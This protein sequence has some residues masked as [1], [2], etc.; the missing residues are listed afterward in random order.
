MSE[1]LKFLCEKIPQFRKSRLPALY[2]DFEH[3]RTINPEG[4]HANISAWLQGLAA[5]A[6]AAAIPT[7]NKRPNLLSFSLN[8][9]LL[10]ALENENV[11]PLSLG[12][13]V[14]EGI[15]NGQLIPREEYMKAF[16][17]IYEKSWARW[18]WKALSQGL[19][20]LGFYRNPKLDKSSTGEFVVLENIEAAAMKAKK[21]FSNFQERHDR[22]FTR[23]KFTEVFENVFDTV[24]PLSDSDMELFL[25]YLARDAGLISYN[26]ELVKLRL[27]NETDQITSDD[28]TI[29]SLKKLI[30][31]LNHQIQGL[32]LR[33]GELTHSAKEA[34]LKNNRTAAL[35]VLKSKSLINQTLEKRYAT[36]AQ[37][38]DVYLKIIQAS[39]QVELVKVMETSTKVL[40]TLNEEVNALGPAEKVVD[41]LQDQ[42]QLVDEINT[43]TALGLTVDEE[44]L[45]LELKAM[46]QNQED[47]ETLETK[48][49]LDALKAMDRP[50]KEANAKALKNSEIQNELA[51][52]TNLLENLSL[53][54]GVK[55]TE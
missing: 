30:E 45:D 47:I 9:D 17:S 32:T 27:A 10:N 55:I 5:A 18:P 52:S 11:Q 37:L 53:E 24:Y 6:R 40:M 51:E 3:L 35:G 39:T 15:E 14:R 54:P 44:M 8:E 2:S 36:L 33:H 22:I 38:E 31:D 28:L 48:T 13:V 1:L 4:Y 29:A 49:K 43:Q 26:P 12:I 16:S 23:A 42:I 21:R 50:S 46:V 19:N 34:V 25:K 41:M 7:I 20:Q